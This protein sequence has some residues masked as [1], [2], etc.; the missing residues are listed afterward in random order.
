MLL[1]PAV[2]LSCENLDGNNAVPLV[3]LSFTLHVVHST[4]LKYSRPSVTDGSRLLLVCDVAL[5]Q[6][7]D[8]LKRDPTLSQAPEG[9]HSVHGVRHT[10]KTPSEFQ[11]RVFA[12]ECKKNSTSLIALSLA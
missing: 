2:T 10:P 12:C 8:V 5:G 9:H 3:S 7:R 6:C 11:V 1:Q 4:S